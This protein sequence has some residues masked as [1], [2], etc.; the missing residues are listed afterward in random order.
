[1]VDFNTIGHKRGENC[2]VDILTRKFQSTWK[3]FNRNRYI[4]M[5]SQLA[6]SIFSSKIYGAI[7]TVKSRAPIN[8]SYLPR[9]LTINKNSIAKN[10]HNKILEKEVKIAQ[11]LIGQGIAYS[12]I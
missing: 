9:V 8:F 7:N 1:M 2:A 6:L 10:L 11:I 4:P 12:I 5:K 3:D